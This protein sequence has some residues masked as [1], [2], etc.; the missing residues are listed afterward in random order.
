MA[1]RAVGVKLCHHLGYFSKHA[2]GSEIRKYS[3]G[4]WDADGKNRSVNGG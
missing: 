2:L 3:L 1:L 4:L